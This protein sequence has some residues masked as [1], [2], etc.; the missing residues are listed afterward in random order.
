MTKKFARI[1]DGERYIEIITPKNERNRGVGR[2]AP[3]NQEP[4]FT[5]EAGPI[6]A[7]AATFRRKRRS[8]PPT[9]ALSSPAHLRSLPTR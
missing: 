8:L 6:P 7:I 4:Q 3:R 9:P 5:M 1:L 2:Y